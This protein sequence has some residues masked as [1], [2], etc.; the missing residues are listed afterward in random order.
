[1]ANQF[2]QLRKIVVTLMRKFKVPGVA[3]SILQNGEII[4]EKGF[5]ARNLEEN[6]PMTPNSLIGIGSISKSFT[7]L[8][9]MILQ[10]RGLLNIE[11]SVAE[12]LNIEPF[13]SH[14]EIK[15]SHLL[16]HSSGIPSVDGNWLPIAITYG[17][18]QRIYP[19]TSREDYLYHLSETKDEIHFKPG[20]KFFYNN[21]MFALLGEIIEKITEKPFEE[22][23]KEEILI[24]LDM[25][26]STINREVLKN[27]P[28]QDYITGY[29]HKGSKEKLVL[30]KPILPFSK[31]LE[32]P[33]G[34]Y[35]SMHEMMNYGNFLINNGVFEDKKLISPESINNLWTPHINSPYGYSKNPTYCLGWMRDDKFFNH[36]LIHHGGGLGVSTAFFGLIPE[37]KI[38]VS[39]AENDDIGICGI[40]G[41]CAILILLGKNP[42]NVNEKVKLFDIYDKIAGKYK[43]S[44]NLYELEVYLEGM[45]IHIKLESDDGIFTYP[46]IIE[47]YDEL[48]FELFSTIPN[49]LQIVKFHLDS[50]SKKVNYVTYDRYLY[51]K[52]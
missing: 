44:L 50:L 48:T 47:D 15:I 39:V 33:G 4:F 52:K 32:A 23:L 16:S 34:I 40:I 45:N 10:E 38:V 22:V 7:A 2:D 31:Y 49:P 27:D 28:L 11:S 43:S 8:L 17:D 18:Y 37:Q 30:E 13:V 6:L 26:R 21:D 20:E 41:I 42:E 12:H 25:N 19:V 29:L 24:P 51:H 36:T 5:G 3:I 1:M 35:A 46:L 14:P 9:I